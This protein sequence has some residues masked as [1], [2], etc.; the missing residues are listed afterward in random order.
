MI[1][2][3]DGNY[4]RHD[5]N[6]SDELYCERGW[7]AT[8]E[9]IYVITVDRNTHIA[10]QLLEPLSSLEMLAENDPAMQNKIFYMNRVARETMAFH[11]QRLNTD[12]NGAD[13]RSAMYASVHQFHKDPER[14]KGIFRAMT[15]G[16]VDTDIVQLTLGELT[17]SLTF[18]PVK[19]DDGT[20]WAFHASWVDITAEVSASTLISGMSKSASEQAAELNTVV[21]DTLLDMN[22][23]GGTLQLVGGAVVANRD[24]SQVLKEQV[25][26]IRKLARTIRGIADQTNMLALNA[27][28]E[29][30]RAG[31]HGRGFAVVADEVRK[32]SQRVQDATEEV[33]KS[34]AAIESSV[35][36]IEGSSQNAVANVTGAE[37]MTSSLRE[38]IDGLNT[39]AIKMTMEAAKQAHILFVR[40]VNE[41]VMRTRQSL[42]A[43][44]LPDHHNCLFGKWYDGLGT[45]LLGDLHEFKALESTH[46]QVNKTGT[47]VLSLLAEGRRKEASSRAHDLKR[48][49]SEILDKLARLG[50]AYSK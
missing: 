40:R 35:S 8:F 42:F 22:E 38:R 2:F 32:L 27:A 44:D 6:C 1:L 7:V 16:V 47:D 26:S 9:E 45:T 29:A 14:I 25:A 46:A 10:Q 43:T 12:L 4:V 36:A 41:Q 30:A 20:V 18:T 28:I 48:L 5:A 39:M 21:S 11:H 15:E 34:I 50:D 33:Q 3:R 31:E 37:S 24:A 19:D 23:V 49:E 17:F 13:V